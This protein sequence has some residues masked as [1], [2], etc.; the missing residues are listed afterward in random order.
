MAGR[1]GTQATA[2]R[3]RMFPIACRLAPRRNHCLDMGMALL[4]V[5]PGHQSRHGSLVAVARCSVPWVYQPLSV[6]SEPPARLDAKAQLSLSTPRINSHSLVSHTRF[7]AIPR[8]I[9]QVLQLRAFPSVVLSLLTPGVSHLASTSLGTDI[10]VDRPHSKFKT[11]RETRAN[12]QLVTVPLPG[13][14]YTQC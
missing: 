14:P 12:T 2:A 6:L 10:S 8:V 1:D 3:P 5:A 7:V 13:L 9:L 4:Q 11:G